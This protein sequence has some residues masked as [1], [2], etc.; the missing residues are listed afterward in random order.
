MG[1]PQGKKGPQVT[2][3]VRSSAFWDL[4]ELGVW[5]SACLC[6]ALSSPFSDPAAEMPRASCPQGL[7]PH[8]D[9]GVPQHRDFGQWLDMGSW[10]ATAE[11]SAALAPLRSPS[12]AAQHLWLGSAF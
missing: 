6:W 8:W 3:C 5:G 4:Q 10:E 7:H 11:L 9:A 12:L 2:M 1:L